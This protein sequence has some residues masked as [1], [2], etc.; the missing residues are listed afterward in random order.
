MKRLQQGFTL[1]ELMIVV[2]IVGILA[3]IALPAYQDYVIRSKMSEGVAALAACK[4]SVSEYV[5]TK[6]AWP[7]DADTAGCSALATQYVSALAVNAN[8]VIVVTTTNTG[9]KSGAGASDCILT[10]AP[11]TAALPEITAWLG[12]HSGCDAKYVPSNFR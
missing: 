8:G 11:Q 12:S 6:N 4:T 2:A 7:A 9:S 5:S 3:A 10:L 1:I